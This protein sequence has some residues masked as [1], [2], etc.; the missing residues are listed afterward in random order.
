MYFSVISG[1]QR[2]ASFT[3]LIC[4][5]SCL[6]VKNA[7]TLNFGLLLLAL[8]VEQMEMST[9]MANA[10]R[11]LKADMVKIVFILLSVLMFSIGASEIAI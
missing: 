3:K 2:L 10:L 7:M 8:S 6:A 5:C 9:A 1:N 4:A 11:V